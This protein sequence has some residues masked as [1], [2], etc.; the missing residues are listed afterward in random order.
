MQPQTVM[1]HHIKQKIIAYCLCQIVLNQKS[2]HKFKKSYKF[3]SCVKVKCTNRNLITWDLP[4]VI[5]TSFIIFH[6]NTQLRK[7]LELFFLTVLLSNYKPINHTEQQSSWHLSFSLNIWIYWKYTCIIFHS[8]TAILQ[9]IT[10]K[11][12]QEKLYLHN[13]KGNLLWYLQIIRN[14]ANY[15]HKSVSLWT[16]CGPFQVFMQNSILQL[17][18]CQK[19]NYFI[20]VWHQKSIWAYILLKYLLAPY[21]YWKSCDHP[22]KVH[23]LSILYLSSIS[24]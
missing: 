16:L 13:S 9:G 4:V 22:M 17:T 19:A 6:L 24:Y 7:T 1:Q 3:S 5:S 2:S 18:V 12:I 21:H 10:V 14:H 23:I 8:G 11:I 15:D 20:S